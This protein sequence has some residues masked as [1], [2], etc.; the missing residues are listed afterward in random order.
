MLVKFLS[1]TDSTV[2]KN[3]VSFGCDLLVIQALPMK[4]FHYVDRLTKHF[5]H[6][7]SG[8][9]NP[10]HLQ[11]VSTKH[12]HVTDKKLE[13]TLW[14]SLNYVDISCPDII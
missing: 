4:M 12:V 3:S 2:V 5:C 6:K 9:T 1:S 13:N 11:C 10:L 7:S 14:D 8:F